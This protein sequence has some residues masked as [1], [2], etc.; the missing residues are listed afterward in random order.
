MLHEKKG[1]HC[2]YT[3]KALQTYRVRC[4]FVVMESCRIMQSDADNGF[5]ISLTTVVFAFTYC[6]FFSQGRAG[7]IGAPGSRGEPGFPVGPSKE[8]V[9]RIQSTYIVWGLFN[10]F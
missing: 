6:L 5:F 7:D 8:Q 4:A 2:V 1:W 9:S 3:V 10:T